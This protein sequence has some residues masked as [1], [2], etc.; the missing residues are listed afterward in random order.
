[1]ALRVTTAR[2][3]AETST[4]SSERFARPVEQSL[5]FTPSV[6]KRSRGVAG[7]R[8]RLRVFDATL[9]QNGGFARSSASTRSGSRAAV[10]LLLASVALG[11]AS[12]RCS[13]STGRKVDV[14][15]RFPAEAAPRV[16]ELMDRYGIGAVIN[17]SGGVPGR[18]LEEQ[19][20]AA[21]RFPGRIVVYAGLDWFE[22][23]RGRGYGARMA[24]SLARAHQL[25]A[26]GLE[27]PRGLGIGFRNGQGD[28]LRVDEP[29][30][31]PVFEKA[32]ELGMPVMIET[33]APMAFWLAPLASNERYEELKAHP[34]LSLFGQAPPW[35]SLFLA[36]ERRIARHP[37]CTFVSAHF[38]NASEHPARVA[39][40]LDKYP[41]LYIDIAGRIPEMGRHPAAEMKKLIS[42]RAD[43]IFF[44]SDL[45]FGRNAKDIALSSAGLVPPSDDEIKHFFSS[46]WRYLETSDK[47]F[48]HPT[49]IQGKWKVNG[50]G[51][52]SSV[53]AKIY[54][55]NAARVL[56]VSAP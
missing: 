47:G 9:G 13:R 53:L 36:L 18:G 8:P 55:E 31:D 30:L 17:L 26:R 32:A 41:N 43:R 28:L 10:C 46:T 22:P 49:P 12:C 24:A 29:E 33:G 21:A 19:L 35:E 2:P 45:A 34:E 25:G 16:V 50:I 23:T 51:L 7:N 20:K 11:Q 27:I 54:G 1:M 37:K 5:P 6:A 48:G 4:P 14:H 39:A 3:G 42:D 15:A 56:K 52:S 38:G 44:G 40:M